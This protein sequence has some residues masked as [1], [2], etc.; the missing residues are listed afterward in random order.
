[1]TWLV[2]VGEP[3]LEGV[4]IHDPT[5]FATALIHAI[6]ASSMEGGN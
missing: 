3:A 2:V 5:G 1:M 4:K 6:I